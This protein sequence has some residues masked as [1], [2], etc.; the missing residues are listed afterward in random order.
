MWWPEEEGQHAAM[1]NGLW[2]TTDRKVEGGTY[3]HKFHLIYCEI[4]VN[5]DKL[6]ALFQRF[7]RV[8]RTVRLSITL[9]VFRHTE[10]VIGTRELSLTAH[11]GTR[12]WRI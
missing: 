7:I 3:K 10:L 6:T 11:D 1:L 9:P 4:N 8:V 2:N 5:I 12:R